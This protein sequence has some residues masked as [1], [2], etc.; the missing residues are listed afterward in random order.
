MATVTPNLR[1]LWELTEDGYERTVEW[2][3]CG[4]DGGPG[5]ELVFH[6]HHHLSD[7]TD[8]RLPYS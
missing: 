5:D 4:T 8:A 7:V 3:D 2:K 1:G 6:P